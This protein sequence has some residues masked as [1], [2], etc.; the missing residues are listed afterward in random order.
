MTSSIPLM[1]DGVNGGLKDVFHQETCYTILAL[2]R[3]YGE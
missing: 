3:D 1:P 2:G